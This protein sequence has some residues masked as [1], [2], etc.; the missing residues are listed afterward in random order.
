MRL[1]RLLVAIFGMSVSREVAFRGN[2]LASAL[3]ATVG[4]AVSLLTIEAVF[5]Q[6]GSLGGWSRGETIVLLGTFQVMS[7]L[8]ATF[9]EPNLLW[10]CNKVYAGGLDEI[11]LKPAPG[12]FLVS[13][14]IH[15]PLGLIQAF[16]GAGIC[17]A[18]LEA[19][20][21]P[22]AVMAWL[23]LLSV[24]LAITW[25]TR[26]AVALIALW[27]PSL[28]LDVVYSALWQFGRY[29][30]AIFE[31]PVR[32]ILTWVVPL[33]FIASLPAQALTGRIDPSMV[34]AAIAV[35]SVSCAAVTVMWRRGLRRY[36][37]ATS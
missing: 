23:A 37:S 20:P 9:I 27:F 30:E 33:V 1:I 7:G 18:G 29:P 34:L 36:A 35:G 5:T 31:R 24:G 10:F 11:L 16:V 32:R 6:T 2:I 19:L 4:A 15:A 12:L 26:V 25:A 14:G 8:L 21:S 17:V 3:Q 28:S 13:L 22:L